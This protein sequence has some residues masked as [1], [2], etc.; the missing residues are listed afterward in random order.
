MKLDQNHIEQIKNAFE[1]MQTKHDLLD[2]MN[3]AKPLIY[4]PNSVPF[5]LK[6]LTWYANPKLR[7]NT[8]KEFKIKKKSGAERSIHAPENGLKAIQKTLS[9]ILHCVYVP[10]KAAMGFVRERSIVDNA[11]IHV[12]SKYVYNL[13]LKDFFPS[14]DQARVWKC[15]QL[16]PL[17]LVSTFEKDNISFENYIFPMLNYNEKN[18][19]KHK[20]HYFNK[21][22]QSGLY[23]I[24][25]E[26]DSELTIKINANYKFKHL[27]DYRVFK[28]LVREKYEQFNPHL[29][30]EI[31][32][33]KNSAGYQYINELSNTIYNKQKYFEIKQSGI[34]DWLL[35]DVLIK[36][37]PLKPN[38][39]GRSTLANMIA[40]LCCTEMNVERKNDKSGE[41]ESVKRNVLPQGA[42]TS[43]ILSN[44]VCQKL[45]FLLTGV[46]KRFGLKYSRYADDITFSSMHNV[47]QPGSEF[48]GELH[49]IITQQ[50]FNIKESKT[51]LQ[52]DGYRKE[53]TG[54]LVNEIPNV[55][56]RYIKQLRMWIYLW[57]KYGYEKANS[58]F[59]KQY[60][61]DKGYVKGDN[62]NMK[63]VILGKL[64][65][66]KMVKGEDNKL[67]MKLQERFDS[68][69]DSQVPTNHLLKTWENQGIEK[70]ME[71]YYLK[72]HADNEK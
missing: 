24:K 40:A 23:Q 6:Q 42:P 38:I 1:K 44:I 53:V 67:H 12:K 39:I 56:K 70:A 52:K 26:N 14:I 65:F 32:V 15:L 19:E 57:E 61:A 33:Y 62:P 9:L 21:Y 5:E 50:N 22:Y 68:L 69:N 11:K 3:I 51:R 46:A 29:I 58:F 18:N 60:F 2:L 59:H 47:Y 31:I 43:P 36:N 66:L 25:M 55:Q 16:K 45:D 37:I 7:K 49:R 72:I 48:I 34:V 64:Q 4:G 27:I 10:N 28:E 8:Y 35:K 41:W 13:D 17:S 20:F 63:T 71:L 54:L 30:G